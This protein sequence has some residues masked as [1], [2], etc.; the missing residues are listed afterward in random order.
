MS[1][2]IRLSSYWALRSASSFFELVRHDKCVNLLS[3][4]D[5]IGVNKDQLRSTMLGAVVEQA[6]NQYKPV[7]PFSAFNI[8]KRSYLVYCR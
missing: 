6:L 2:Q 1:L 7:T 3:I 4:S 5:I 8:V